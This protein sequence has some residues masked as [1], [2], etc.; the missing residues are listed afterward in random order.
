MDDFC[1]QDMDGGSWMTRKIIQYGYPLVQQYARSTAPDP[2]FP[3]DTREL[4]LLSNMARL[5]GGADELSKGGRPIGAKT[6][7]N[8]DRNGGVGHLQALTSD[9]NEYLTDLFLKGQP[10]E[11]IDTV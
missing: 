6:G 11:V 8:K 10:G 5:S 1:Q 3:H 4:A 9:E 2:A 7:S